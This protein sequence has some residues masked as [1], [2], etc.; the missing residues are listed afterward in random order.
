MPRD[1]IGLM[2]PQIPA[3]NYSTSKMLGTT[4]HSPVLTPQ[5]SEPTATH[6]FP[7]SVYVAHA[8]LGF[9]ASE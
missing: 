8:V 5:I 3:L 1:D 4:Q 2:R 7:T 9:A 6:A